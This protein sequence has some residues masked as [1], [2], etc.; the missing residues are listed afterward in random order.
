MTFKNNDVFSFYEKL[1]FNIF[2]DINLALEQVK[3]SDPLI[4]YPELGKIFDKYKK[5]KI[6]D[7]GWRRLACKLFKLS[8]W[9]KNSNYRSRF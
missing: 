7:F 2:G 6:I 9:K 3:K 5:I 8:S 1:P 4:T